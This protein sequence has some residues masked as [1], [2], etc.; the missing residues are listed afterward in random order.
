MKKLSTCLLLVLLFHC[1]NIHGINEVKTKIGVIA[2][3]ATLDTVPAHKFIYVSDAGNFDKPPW[4]IL[5]FDINGENPEVFIDQNQG[6]SWPQ[7]IVFLDT[8]NEV[9]ISNLN[10]GVI[11]RHNAQTGVLIDSFASEIGGPTRMKIGPDGLLYVLQWAGKGTV[12]RYDLNGILKDEFT[13][14]KIPQSIGLDWDKEGNLY[15]SSFAKASIRKFD[16][17]GNDIG[18]FIDNHLQGPTNI[19]FD[20]KGNM[21]V[22]DWKA[23]LVAKF[24]RKGKFIENIITGLLQVEGV[25]YFENGD[26]L[27]GNG[28]KGEVKLY[29][30]NGRFKKSIIESGQG[31]L[32]RPN[33]VIIR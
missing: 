11:S 19:W 22:S 14:T 13:S 32:I 15:V 33:A 23:G 2:H 12:L 27:I 26:F 29:K 24:D 1:L 10:T 3:R 21:L 17:K 18:V 8:K 31:N 6:L 16:S 7:D 30:K 25:D 9:L 28:G 5:K 20:Q 4:Q